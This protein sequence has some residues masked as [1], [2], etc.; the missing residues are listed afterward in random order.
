MWRG[1]FY[2]ADYLLDIRNKSLMNE[3]CSSTTGTWLELG[4]GVGL[5]SI[6]A[7][8]IQPTYA[9]RHIYAT[10][11]SD[12]I[13]LTKRN[14]DRNISHMNGSIEALPLNVNE[15]KPSFNICECD[16]ELILAADV[17]YDDSLTDDIIKTL[18][19]LI[20]QQYG[21]QNPNEK[22]EA[23][24]ILT[25]LFSVEKR[26]N[27]TI[28]NMEVS[29]HAYDYFIQRLKEL[30]ENMKTLYNGLTISYNTLDETIQWFCYERSKDLVI[31][32]IEVMTP[33]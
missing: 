25:C 7:A 5:V 11:I 13:S 4:A 16:I 17:I 22:H 3:I 1:S 24:K 14:I 29:A 20:V 28:D 27:F 12:V 30:S 31:I 8:M 33:G 2:L 21:R 6:V 19:T 10:D 26:F 32:K 15:N 9:K 23:C 18:R